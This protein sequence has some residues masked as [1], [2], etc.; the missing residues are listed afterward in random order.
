LSSD[1]QNCNYFLA[2][3]S[4]NCHRIHHI[5]TKEKPTSNFPI[6]PPIIPCQKDESRKEIYQGR[7]TQ[8]CCRISSFS[9]AE[10]FSLCR[11]FDGKV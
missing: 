6:A 10:K 3:A 8:E 1:I 7:K 11:V 5:Y 9:D 2:K 4:F